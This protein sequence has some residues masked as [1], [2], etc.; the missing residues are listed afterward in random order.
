[1]IY[2]GKHDLQWHSMI[3]SGTAWFSNHDLQWRSMIYSGT[4]RCS[5]SKCC[6]PL[7]FVY[8]R[9]LIST[10]SIAVDEQ[11]FCTACCRRT[12]SALTVAKI[13][14]SGWIVSVGVREVSSFACCFRVDSEWEWGRC[15]RLP[16]VSGWIVSVGVTEVSSI[17][18]CFRVDSVSESE[19]RC[20][21]LPVVS[22]WIYKCQ[23]EWVE[24]SSFAV[25]GWIVSVGVSGGVIV[26]LLIFSACLLVHHFRWVTV[27]RQPSLH[28]HVAWDLNLP[29]YLIPVS[30][31]IRSLTV[32]VCLIT[33]TWIRNKN[34]C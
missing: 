4:A 9:T 28:H 19:W 11:G 34:D 17:A 12:V 18:C 15:H 6:S 26:C 33:L 14:V 24:V 25:S 20:H 22:G 1:M 29:T 23:W 31:T 27:T 13:A 8:W 2:S 16:A 5:Q 10:C 7:L 30:V 3:Y 32:S 21:R